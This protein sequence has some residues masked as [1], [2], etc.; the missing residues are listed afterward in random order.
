MRCT[1]LDQSP[2]DYESKPPEGDRMFHKNTFR[3]LPLILLIALLAVSG[4]G[5]GSKLPAVG[6]VA[7]TLVISVEKG[8]PEKPQGITDPAAFQA[9]LLLALTARDT[10]L[11]QALSSAPFLTGTWRGDLSG[12]SPA[13]ALKEL[14]A[15]QFG[16]KT[17]LAP[18]KDA[19]LKTLMGGKDP[20][21][22]PP[23]EAGVSQALLVSGWGK[24]G[25]D[26][27]I[28]FVARQ[29]DASLKWHGWL[30]VQGGFSGARLGGIQPYQNDAFGISL[31]LPKNFEIP[32]GVANEIAFLGP[33]KGHP[34]DYRVGVY[35]FIEPANGR[36][37]DQVAMQT[38][39]EAKTQVGAG[40][41]GGVVTGMTIEGDAAY[42]VN[43]LP[44]QDFNRLLF[45][46]H[47][48]QLYKMMFIP[49]NPRAQAYLQM[50]DAY[51]MIVNTLHF[52]Q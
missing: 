20:L 19:D 36:T 22:I 48:G 42:S 5:L 11:L 51:A 1:F 44:G 15:D 6:G 21:S 34:D 7:P 2:A 3:A 31:F 33:G 9:A 41:S 10:A 25:R 14:Y 29:A 30:R 26:E 35:I 39:Q 12:T 28:L 52:T 38:A 27:A 16:D 40:Y 8:E 43:Q 13:D 45:V 32:A 46:V 23:A 37:A 17:N 18:V 50:E 24:D 47:G 4:C 49:D